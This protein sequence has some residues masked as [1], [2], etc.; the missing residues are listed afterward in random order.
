MTCRVTASIR[1]AGPRA[2]SLS[3][4]GLAR[5]R[6]GDRSPGARLGDGRSGVTR[7]V[8][9]GL[10][11]VRND[12][13]L[14]FDSRLREVAPP[15]VDTRALERALGEVGPSGA[16]SWRHTIAPGRGVVQD[17]TRCARSGATLGGPP[18]LSGT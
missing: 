15:R 10:R 12:A 13:A 2:V 17:Y 5:R 14:L 8:V 4:S 6:I 16:T 1:P 18:E 7:E 9:S 3:R 11:P